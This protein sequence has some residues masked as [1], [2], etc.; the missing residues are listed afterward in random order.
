MTIIR[1][2]PTPLSE[3][4]GSMGHHVETPRVR[5]ESDGSFGHHVEPAAIT[6][7][8][9]VNGVKHVLQASPNKPQ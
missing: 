9:A 4:K 2:K 1:H 7:T 5:G 3:S 8:S 6:V